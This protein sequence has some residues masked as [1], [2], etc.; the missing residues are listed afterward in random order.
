MERIDSIEGL[1]SFP[2]MRQ[3]LERRGLQ[4]PIQF[5]IGGSDY[6]ELAQWRDIIVS[7]AEKSG[8]LTQIHYD[9]Q[10]TKPQLSISINKERAALL[11]VSAL[12]IGRSLETFL[13]AR[14][15]TTYFDRG[16]EYNIVLQAQDTVRHAPDDLQK[17]YIKSDKTGSS[18]PLANLLT[19]Q[20]TTYSAYLNRYNRIRS[21][22]IDANLAP[23]VTIDKA[24]NFLDEV[25]KKELPSEAVISYKGP[26]LDFK[27]SQTSGLWIFAV[28]LL[29]I[30]LFLAAQFE[31][32]IQPFVIMSTV[33]LAILGALIGLFL[34]NN[35]LNIFSQIG[36]FMLI[37]LAAKNGILIVEFTNQ[38]RDR[39][40]SPLRALLTACVVR[41]RPILMTSLA[42]IM[43]AIPLLISMGA[44]AE[45][46]VTIGIV[47]C[48]GMVLTT[49]F[50]LFVV[51]VFYFLI[52]KDTSS[53]QTYERKLIN[54]ENTFEDKI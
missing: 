50:T 1:Q 10:E 53:P 54:F 15:V 32:F 42:T 14:R 5:V 28:A 23:G 36:L 35:S 4:R 44:G 22:T 46:R 6:K 19:F 45:T 41:L 7:K 39:G 47:I 9:Y 3:G 49:F 25:A 8:L 37:G 16:E 30:Y 40:L 48:F 12:S 24:L 33:P 51:P 43:G 13:N 29:V 27:E 34:L 21:I 26:S 18:I 17:I 31:S 20:E 11:G 2:V 38:L 52:A